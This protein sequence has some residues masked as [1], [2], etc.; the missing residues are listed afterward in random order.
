M[1]KQNKIKIWVCSENDFRTLT[2]GPVGCARQWGYP[3]LLLPP[4]EL[5]KAFLWPAELGGEPH[6]SPVPWA[7]RLLPHTRSH[8]HWQV[9][10]HMHAD[11]CGM[12]GSVH[13]THRG[14]WLLRH[15][16]IKMGSSNSSEGESNTLKKRVCDS[17]QKGN[18]WVPAN[19][20]GQGEGQPLPT[21]F[22]SGP[23]RSVDWAQPNRRL[24]GFHKFWGIPPL[25]SQRL[26]SRWGGG[27]PYG[28]SETLSP[29]SPR[30]EEELEPPPPQFLRRPTRD[31]AYLSIQKP[32][33]LS[34][35]CYAFPVWKGQ[36]GPRPYTQHLPPHWRAGCFP[37]GS[38]SSWSAQQLWPWPQAW[39]SPLEAGAPRSLAP[40]SESQEKP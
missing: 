5:P 8:S 21:A 26:S 20:R 15:T 35:V 1:G 33:G 32:N 12:Q 25:T 18:E 40:W 4:S 2:F 3:T 30:Q 10:T 13:V 6:P 7:A 28:M 29:G 11:T 27:W 34:C 38:V 19:A 9:H 39:Y 16:V 23:P 17:G 22:R 37:C 31:P 36:R 24:W 14:D